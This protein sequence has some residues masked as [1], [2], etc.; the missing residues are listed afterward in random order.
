MALVE[1]MKMQ[2]RLQKELV[3]RTRSYLINRQMERKAEQIRPEQQR[4]IMLKLSESLR[5]GT[6]ILM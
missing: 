6:V 5:N 3:S 2:Y 4:E 1:Q